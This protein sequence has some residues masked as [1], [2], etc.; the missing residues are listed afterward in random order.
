MGVD[1]QEEVR[2]TPAQPI[3]RTK[4]AARQIDGQHVEVLVMGYMDRIMVTVSMEGKIGH[5]VVVVWS[6]LTPGF[7]WSFESGSCA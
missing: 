1:S 4:Q 5:L 2:I 6:A 3:I 7:N